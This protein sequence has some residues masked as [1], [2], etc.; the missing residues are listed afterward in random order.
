MNPFPDL[1]ATGSQRR[2]GGNSPNRGGRGGRRGGRGGRTPVRPNPPRGLHL[3]DEE[4]DDE[5]G[6][7]TFAEPEA[8]AHFSSSTESS[9]ND[10]TPPASTQGETFQP[11]MA[12]ASSQHPASEDVAAHVPE[13][14]A[15]PT[16]SYNAP[17]SAAEDAAPYQDEEMP[18][19]SGMS[20]AEHVYIPTVDAQDFTTTEET[21]STPHEDP[22]ETLVEAVVQVDAPPSQV[23]EEEKSDDSWEV[24]LASF[25]KNLPSS[26]SDSDSS[27]DS[28]Q[29]EE[30]D[31]PPVASPEPAY[32]LD[33]LEDSE[34]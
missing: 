13:N 14:A 8:R 11:N 32:I 17:Q 10:S 21:P 33:E 27:E 19:F 3:V 7:P 5:E 18:D 29:M 15:A 9:S 12:A 6:D 25:R 34:E 20:S 31:A 16:V 4:T 22:L 23:K 1:N 28:S 30:D 24:P 2:R 26:E